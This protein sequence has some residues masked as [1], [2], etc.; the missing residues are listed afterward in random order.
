MNASHS[1]EGVKGFIKLQSH[2]YITCDEK[3]RTRD[4][5]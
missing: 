4:F 3:G 1:F 2:D 5:S